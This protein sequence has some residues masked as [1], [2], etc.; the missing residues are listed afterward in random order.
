MLRQNLLPLR[1]YIFWAGGWCLLQGG[2]FAFLV[3][4]LAP[5]LLRPLNTLDNFLFI[6]NM[7]ILSHLK[8]A[9]MLSSLRISTFLSLFCNPLALMYFHNLLTI[10]GLDNSVALPHTACNSGLRLYF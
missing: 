10:W 2:R 9:F 6:S 1:R 3:A 7:V 5:L 8:T 4:L